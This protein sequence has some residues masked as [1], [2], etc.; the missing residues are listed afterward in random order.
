VVD[1]RIRRDALTDPE[2]REQV[3]WDV[4]APAFGELRT[5]YEPDPRLD[6]LTPGQRALYALHWARSEIGNGGFHQYLY[7]STGMLANEA[8]RGAGLIGATD[9]A[10]LFREVRTLVFGNTFIEDQSRRIDVLEGLSEEAL[11]KLEELTDRF[12]EL[13]GSADESALARYCSGY[14]DAHSADFFL[15][16]QS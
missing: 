16:T 12:Y 13:M 4:I 5:P 15:P 9:F 10:E 7:N 8:L 11:A 1:F 14:V 3:W 2:D 6:E